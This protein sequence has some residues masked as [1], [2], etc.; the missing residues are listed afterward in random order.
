M[1][2]KG[3]DGISRK[4]CELG[5][6]SSQEGRDH[7]DHCQDEQTIPKIVHP[8]TTR[9]T[10]MGPPIRDTLFCPVLLERRDH[11]V[12]RVMRREEDAFPA[13]SLQDS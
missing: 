2:E 7:N 9:L 3:R 1:A 13:V 11:I 12:S 10:F 5:R 8:K 4:S 6:R